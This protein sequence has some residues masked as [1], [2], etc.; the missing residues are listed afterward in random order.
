MNIVPGSPWVIDTR[1]VHLRVHSQPVLRTPAGQDPI[2]PTAVEIEYDIT[3]G[4]THGVIVIGERLNPGLIRRRNTTVK[5]RI[6][7]LDE[8]PNWVREIVDAYRPVVHEVI[9]W[10]DK[11]TPEADGA[12]YGTAM[13]LSAGLRGHV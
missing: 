8:A 9:N 2:N 5:R 11:F 4:R 13:E 7:V 10:L 1:T 6:T 3:T 12:A